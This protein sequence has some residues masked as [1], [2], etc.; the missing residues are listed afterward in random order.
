M[1]RSQATKGNHIISAGV[2]AA[3]LTTSV[4]RARAFVAGLLAAAGLLLP[5]A[6]SAQQVD[7]ERLFRQRCG[8]CHSL[9]PGQNRV[10]PHLSGVIGRMAGSV[11]DGRYSAALRESGIVW[12]S[13]SLDAFLAA[14]R[15]RVPG[16][17]MTV[18][19]PNAAQRAAIIVYLEGAVTR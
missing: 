9:E 6:A 11:E 7:G 10:G 16:T 17:S 15:Q 14:P 13:Q 12:D 5:A 2:A 18:G 3:S 1:N 4:T 8:T 19:V